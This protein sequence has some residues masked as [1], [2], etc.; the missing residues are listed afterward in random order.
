MITSIV[1]VRHTFT[2]AFFLQITS[3]EGNKRRLLLATRGGHWRHCN[4]RRETWAWTLVADRRTDGSAEIQMSPRMADGGLLPR[5]PT[6]NRPPARTHLFPQEETAVAESGGGV[7][8]RAAPSSASQC[9]PWKN[10]D[11]N[12]TSGQRSDFQS[13]DKQRH[14]AAKPTSNKYRYDWNALI[15]ENWPEVKLT[16]H[17]LLLLLKSKS[18]FI[19]VFVLN[20]IYQK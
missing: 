11:V 16:L 10:G 12:N 13:R 4:L 6:W 14:L 2:S 20:D 17:L 19:V 7:V 15:V 1:R 3:T 18:V 8:R 9:C 5:W